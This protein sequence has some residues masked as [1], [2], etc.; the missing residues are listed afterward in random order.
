MPKKVENPFKMEY[1]PELDISPELDSDTVQYHLTII[2][3]L[4]WMIELGVIP[5][6]IP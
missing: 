2:G 5:H 4:R 3:V 1:D 6:S